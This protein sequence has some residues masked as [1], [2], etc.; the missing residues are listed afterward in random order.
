MK[1]QNFLYV[2]LA[3][4]LFTTGCKKQLD[5]VNPNQQTSE[6]FWKSQADAIAGVNAIY[7]SLLPDGGYMRCTPL[8]MD[9]RGDDAKSNSPWDQMYNSGKLA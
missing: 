8:M 5:Q 1:K 4:G 2:I 7:S 6:T 3:A 9:T